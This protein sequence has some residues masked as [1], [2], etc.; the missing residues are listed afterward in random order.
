MTKASMYNSIWYN[1][2]TDGC[3]VLKL[4]TESV[5]LQI[6]RKKIYKF[7]TF[8]GDIEDVRNKI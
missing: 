7:S 1:D 5:E 3:N 6:K 8:H 4:Q 2:N